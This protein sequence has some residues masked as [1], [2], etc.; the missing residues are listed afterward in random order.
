MR[1]VQK[2]WQSFLSF[3]GLR[4]RVESMD[5]VKGKHAGN[6][7]KPFFGITIKYRAFLQISS[8]NSGQPSIIINQ[9]GYYML[10]CEVNVRV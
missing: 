5:W 1:Y 9:L 7:R 8:S 3:G 10:E 4:F 2:P 6:I